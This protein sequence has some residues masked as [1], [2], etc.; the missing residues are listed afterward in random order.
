ME[1][2][3]RDRTK[4]RGKGLGIQMKD[5]FGIEVS[6]VSK[7]FS[8]SFKASMNYGVRDIFRDVFTLGKPIS[9]LRKG[10][11]WA[12]DD[13]SF[14]LNGGE[15]VGVIGSNG[16][17]KSTL[18]KMINGIYLP[19]RG[20][21]TVRGRVG[22]L[23]ELGAGFHPMLTGKENI[24]VNAAILGIRKKEVDEKLTQI[25]EF[26]GIG[27]FLNMPVKFYSS[28]MHARL[29]FSVAAHMDADV[30]LVDEVLAVGDMQ[31]QEKCMKHMLHLM[32]ADKCVILVSHSLY[33]IESLCTRAVWLEKGRLMHQGPAKEVIA[34][35]LDF[36]EKQLSEGRE[37]GKARPEKGNDA[38]EVEKTQLVDMKGHI[39]DEFP[40]GSQMGIRINCFARERT[41]RPLFN[42]RILCGNAAI[43]EAGMNVDGHV[44]DW[45]EEHCVV[46]C[47]FTRPLPLTPKV[48][49]VL[50]WVSN[51]VGTVY[52]SEPKIV[53]KFRVT[54]EGLDWN[55]YKGPMAV[56]H[57]RQGS[58][59]CLP[60]EWRIYN[61]SSE[62]ALAMISITY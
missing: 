53:A 8:G 61:P 36:Q 30:L 10:E 25:I 35:Y 51:E 62:D 28:G 42:I 18:L 49:E 33:R 22:A 31:F 32:R 15:I 60:H 38:V 48:Y 14:A 17:G 45:I 23:I 5:R 50:L 57:M 56:N 1:S 19:D 7:K 47:L 54:D 58:P 12:I 24:Y 13:L 34:T 43:L 29:G 4:T 20:N 52:L 16:S 9:G 55:R 21:I 11:F 39:R 46:E 41:F 44:Q 26:A 3:A 27:D 40:F 59:V 6:N 2:L 37:A